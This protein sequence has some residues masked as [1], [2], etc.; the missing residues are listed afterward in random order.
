LRRL[1]GVGASARLAV[2]VGD[3]R[4]SGRTVIEARNGTSWISE[5]APTIRG[6]GNRRPGSAWPA[7][8]RGRRARTCPDGRA[9]GAPAPTISVRP[10]GAWTVRSIVCLPS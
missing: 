3:V 4:L 1:F 6:G 8:R 5:H 7:T 10:S 2:A 9:W